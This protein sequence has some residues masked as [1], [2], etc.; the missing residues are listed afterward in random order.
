MI[1]L[2]LLLFILGCFFENG[3]AQNGICTSPSLSHIHDRLARNQAEFPPTNAIIRE[4]QYVPVAFHIV[5]NNDGSDRLS[6]VQLL[7]MLCFLNSAYADQDIQFYMTNPPVQYLQNSGVNNQP[8]SFANEL[9]NARVP[10]AVNVFITNHINATIGAA[11]YYL[12]P[13]GWDGYDF[14]V[15]AR[16]FIYAGNV[17]PHEIGHFF[18]LLHPFHGWENNPWNE[19]D[20]GNPVAAVAPSDPIIFP[21]PVATENQNGSNCST[22]GDRI[23]DT[24]P[25][26]LFALN[27]QQNNCEEWSV[28]VQDPTGAVVNPMESNTM[29]YFSNC[30][31]YVFTPQQKAAIANDLM[32][33]PER[34]YVRQAYVPNMTAI[35]S[36]PELLS[37]A[38]GSTINSSES[39]SLSWFP[40]FEAQYY[41]VE[42]DISPGFASPFRQSK[43]VEAA[44]PNTTFGH[45]DGGTTYYWRVR[46]FT[47]FTTCTGYSD[48]GEFT[49]AINTSTA[50]EP[51]ATDVLLFPN[52]IGDGQS[53]TIDFKNNSSNHATV[54]LLNLTGQT[55][56][57]KYIDI[58]ENNG[59]ANISTG[60]LANGVYILNI[61][62]DGK[63]LLKYL[64]KE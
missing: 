25:D 26:Y 61:T 49:T 64:V 22:A 20:W 13:A 44:V 35:N 58:P 19:N 45:L 54:T 34:A 52:P 11:G 30:T 59:T 51:D 3:L 50:N 55:L 56:M 31:G 62:T 38:Q 2:Y 4:P 33:A 1:R 27:N 63:T 23:C 57:A 47:E 7:D 5:S 18:S 32:N 8:G 46:P 40:I 16:N 28:N 53:L 9:R 48:R 43:I 29:S 6:D 24:P 36:V 10:N 12:G 14:I 17:F 37:P 21:T 39:V 60:H 41:A 15:I 42:I